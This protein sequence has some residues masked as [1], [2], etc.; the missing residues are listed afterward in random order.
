MIY[1]IEVGMV[2]IDRGRII[3]K[4]IIGFGVPNEEG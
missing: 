1:I 2:V 3:L 4:I